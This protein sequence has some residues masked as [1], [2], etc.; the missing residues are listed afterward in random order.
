MNV[1]KIS[2]NN[3][4]TKILKLLRQKKILNNKYFKIT[5]Y[6]NIPIGAGLGGS[7]SNATTLLNYLIKKFNL[8]ISRQKILKLLSLIGKDCSLFID[9]KPKLIFNYGEKFKQI[10]FRTR[11]RLLIIY[12]NKISLS[13]SVYKKNNTFSSALKIEKILSKKKLKYNLLKNDLLEASSRLTPEIP[14][15]LKLFSKINKCKYY[16]ITGSGSACFGI[17]GDKKSLLNA[18]KTFKRKYRNY[19]TAS[20]K[21]IN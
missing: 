3:S 9:T 17:F 2:K 10:K 21:T 13:K 19:W 14:G 12:P 7:S 8:K 15:I 18:R 20:V 1:K 4:I 11:L 5:I 16:N 6:K